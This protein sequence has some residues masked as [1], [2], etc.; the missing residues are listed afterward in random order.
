MAHSQFVVCSTETGIQNE[1]VLKGGLFVYQRS[2]ST[3]T[4]VQ[5]VTCS[6][7]DWFLS[8]GTQRIAK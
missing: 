7:F 2:R 3:E 8:K 4:C 6:R 5:I 1:A